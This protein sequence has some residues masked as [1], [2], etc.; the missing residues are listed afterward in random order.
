[1]ME[2]L[3]LKATEDL[4]PKERYTSR[5]FLMLEMEKLW[6]RVWQLVCR[7]EELPN[8]GDFVEY[9][10]GDQSFLIVRTAAS[11]IRAFANA[12]LHRGTMLRTG[13]GTIRGPIR[14]RYHGWAWNFDGSIREVP[15]RREFAP[16][17]VSNE[18]LQL[19]QARVETWGGFVFINMD[20]EAESLVSFLAPIPERL[21]TFEL[22]KMRYVRYRSTV[23]PCNWKTAMDAFNEVYHIEGTHVHDIAG[24]SD[25]DTSEL[26]VTDW[27]RE[28]NV[29]NASRAF[30]V[31]NYALHNW[32]TPRAPRTR[33]RTVGE[34]GSDPRSS[35]ARIVDGMA[36][37]GLCHASEVEYILDEANEIP[38]DQTVNDCL[39]TIRR[40]LGRR[41]GIDYSKVTDQDMRSGPLTIHFFPNVSAPSGA[42]NCDFFRFRPNA[43]D[44]DSCIYDRIFLHRFPEGEEPAV[45]REWIED[46]REYGANWGQLVWQDLCNLEHIQAG[47]HQRSFRGLR[48]S[49]MENNIRNFHR[50]LDAYMS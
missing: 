10:I 11:E 15:D 31:E 27:E 41:S 44:P 17:C 16:P 19:P 22:E 36:G 12:C 29:T 46:W 39:V 35:L 8:A 28:D 47:M 21:K 5:E 4:I 40:E 50:V 45:E 24:V 43:L 9:S 1:M 20:F 48:L 2:A 13:N 23:L 49:T 3:A 32:I 34:L 37:G 7:E 30:R 42:V 38:L 18:A 6:P 33:D 26:V 25:T 14:C